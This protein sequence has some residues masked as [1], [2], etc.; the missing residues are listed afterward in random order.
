M[1][2]LTGP[3]AAN[4]RRRG[5]AIARDG[6]VDVGDVG[7]DEA[8]WRGYEDGGISAETRKQR[9]AEFEEKKKK[10]GVSKEGENPARNSRF[11][12]RLSGDL[13]LRRGFQPSCDIFFDERCVGVMDRIREARRGSMAAVNGGLARRR[14]RS[15]SLRDSPDEDG[16]MEMQE[17]VR[18]RDRGSKKDRDRD[19]SGRNKRRRG[20]R[21]LHGS[22]REEGDD[23]SEESLDEDDDDEEDDSTVAGRLPTPSAPN[24][25]PT[26]PVMLNHHLRKGFPAKSARAPGT[27]TWKVVE[28]MIGASIPRKARSSSVKRSQECWLSGGGGG[29]GDQ[30]HRQA[31]MSPARPSPTSTTPVSPSSSN[32]SVRKK[33]KLISG[34]K[35]RLSKT[36]KTSSIQE[37]EI[38]V[39]EVLFGM[40]RQVPLKPEDQKH[41][42]KE[43]NGSGLEVKSRVSPPYPISSP[44]ATSPA[45]ARPSNPSSNAAP[46][47]ATAPKRKLPRKRFEDESPTSPPNSHVL[48]ATSNSSAPKLETEAA[49]PPP[50]AI[51]TDTSPRS[52][53]KSIVHSSVSSEPVISITSAAAKVQQETVKQENIMAPDRKDSESRPEKRAKEEAICPP[54]EST[55]ANLDVKVEDD[56]ASKAVVISENQREDKFS[57]DLMALP[58]RSSPEMENS[59]DNVAEFKS[60]EME[61]APAP[62]PELSKGEELEKTEKKSKTEREEILL[63]NNNGGKQSTDDS[64]LK[65]QAGKEKNLDLLLDLEKIDKDVNGSN[66]NQ[67]LKQQSRA[68]RAE[69][70]IEKSGLPASSSPMAMQIPGWPGGF[71]P[72]GILAVWLDLQSAQ[73]GI[74]V[75][76]LLYRRWS[77]ST[78]APPVPKQCRFLS[79]PRFHSS[80]PRPILVI[81]LIAGEFSAWQSFLPSQLRPKRCAAHCYIAQNIHYHQ[82]I[83]RLN[84]FWPSAPGAAPMYAAK[85][86]NLNTAPPSDATI[87]AGA[88]PGSLPGRSLGSVQEKPGQVSA[89][90]SG[91]S[92]KD[93]NSATSTQFIDAASQRKVPAAL[94]QSAQPG[95]A[96]NMLAPAFIFPMHQQQAQ[97]VTQAATVG[98]ANRSVAAKLS[99]GSGNAAP[100]STMAASGA[101][102]PGM[103]MNFNY[104]GLPPNEQYLAFLQNN[105]YSFPIP[106]HVSGAPSYR[107]ANPGQTLPYFNLSFYSPSMIHPTQLRLQQPP[108][109]TQQ[110]PP[111]S[112]QGHQNPSTSSGSSSS[113]KNT[114]QSQRVP[115]AAASA[116]TAGNSHGFPS[117]KQQ[118]LHQVRQIEPE[119]VGE[120]APSTADSRVSQAQK[121]MY[122]QKFSVPAHS[123][124]F[125]L[126]APAAAALSGGGSVHS[127]KQLQAQ[128]QVMKMDLTP[129]QAFAMSFASFGGAAAASTAAAPHGFDFSSISQNHAL[130][131]SL[132]EPARQGYQVSAAAHSAQQRHNN[133][134][135]AEDGKPAPDLGNTNAPAEEAKNSPANKPMSNSQPQSLTF[136][137]ADTEPPMSS[138]IN[139]SMI[140][141]SSRT[142]NLIQQPPN[143]APRPAAS[144][145]SANVYSDRL[146]GNSAAASKY[147]QGLAGFPPALTQ[148]SASAQPAQWK[149]AAR[150]TNPPSAATTTVVVPPPSSSS[151]K[152]QMPLQQQVRGQQPS[153]AHQPHQISFGVSPAKVAVQL[154]PAS[155]AGSPQ[156]SVSKSSVGSPHSSSAIPKSAP[157]PSPVLPV[158]PF[159]KLQ[160][161]KNSSTSSNSPLPV[162]TVTCPPSSATHTTPPQPP[163]ST[164]ARSRCR[165]PSISSNPKCPS[166]I[167]PKPSSSSPTPTCKH[168]IPSLTW[169]LPPPPA[170]SSNTTVV[171]RTSNNL[172]HGRIHC[173]PPPPVCSPSAPLHHYHSPQAAVPPR[174][175]EGSRRSSPTIEQLK[176]PDTCGT[177][178]ATPISVCSCITTWIGDDGSGGR[179]SYDAIH[180]RYAVRPVEA[181]RICLRRAETGCW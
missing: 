88:L 127:E 145:N 23:S 84:P 80:S 144:H 44:I 6:G 13:S 31:S 82:Q 81:K 179:P 28:E 50:A 155:T 61:L 56:L 36:S 159:Q 45:A 131:Q 111:Y 27:G 98:A 120:D 51:K 69:Q 148:S 59:S 106:A 47:T 165:P 5:P 151:T 4:A 123:Q 162:V 12:S 141:G 104:P 158:M 19:R 68:P 147:A 3:S 176:E 138:I 142:L 114:Q 116:A 91:L 79:L 132:P 164:W 140:D 14:Q 118:L 53:K 181:R 72:F 85:Q 157:P 125:A 32:V 130:F 75:Q 89:A 63:A 20:D 96:G 77:P 64:D 42:P 161:G 10:T 99:P 90:Y 66:K 122:S 102:G 153:A 7:V 107:P 119:P 78:G 134:K 48:P 95:S 67:S 150:V 128:N 57:F 24:P 143:G 152:S 133:S 177:N 112:Q 171:N 73:R 62:K 168:R 94:Q 8:T 60:V 39:A 126:I 15:S 71:P 70:K 1:M 137:R 156:N 52:E 163:H 129:S 16:A 86:Y 113:Q 97:A 49:P 115:T 30:I 166:S 34:S 21:M 121:S 58:G 136:T 108:P 93:K 35:Q 55:C 43:S 180:P 101:N 146:P 22:H 172:R 135:K 87:I 117:S 154:G 38:E 174:P 46:L 92:S 26:A 76:F 178:A 100:P 105:A 160:S 83:T 18:L 41:D 11:L 175:I 17:T 170:T 25:T 149:A 29:G 169:W 37:I 9:W 103:T 40:T 173:P 54:K 74:W 167:S 139:N 33:V 2:D 109:G 124:N 65:K 110:P